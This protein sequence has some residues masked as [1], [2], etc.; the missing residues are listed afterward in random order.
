MIE[1]PEGLNRKTVERAY[2]RAKQAQRNGDIRLR[3]NGYRAARARDPK[4]LKTLEGMLE[5]M[6]GV[7]EEQTGRMRRDSTRSLG[8]RVTPTEVQLLRN[9]YEV[10]DKGTDDQA[11]L[12]YA[13]VYACAGELAGIL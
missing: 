4:L 7:A 9:A 13:W 2:G 11:L 6:H 10:C 3:D 5:I 12:P 1:L 8:E